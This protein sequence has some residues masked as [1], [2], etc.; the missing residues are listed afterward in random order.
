MLRQLRHVVQAGREAG[1]P[2]S[3]CGEMAS[4]ALGALLLL[5][6]GFESLSV[7]PPTLPRV[8]WLVRKVPMTVCREAARAALDAE[9]A[10]EV[11]SLLREAVQG[12]VDKRFLPA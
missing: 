10:T 4:E 2:V 11:Q 7:A 6:L 8:K 1:I 12:F 3:V 5:G 9:T